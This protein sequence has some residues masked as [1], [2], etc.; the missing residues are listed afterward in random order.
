MLVE[1]IIFTIL[2]TYLLIAIFFKFIKNID[3]TYIFIL[4][5]Q[6]FGLILGIVQIIFRLKFGIFI[7]SIMYL[8]SVV[9]PVIIILIEYK[10]RNFIELVYIMLAKFYEIIRK[11]KKMQRNMAFIGR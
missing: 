5:M 3:K 6:L 10:G 9:I 11:Y 7:K 2:A 8:V 1:Q 4:I